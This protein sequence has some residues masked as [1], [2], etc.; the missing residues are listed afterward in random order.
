MTAMGTKSSVDRPRGAAEVVAR[1]SPPLSPEKET[2]EAEQ[3]VHQLY[4]WML[5]K[6]VSR[7]SK[8]PLP[9]KRGA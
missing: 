2:Y 1:R 9:E 8:L 7:S 5:K 6:S 4:V 3:M